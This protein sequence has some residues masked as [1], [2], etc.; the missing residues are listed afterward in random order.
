MRR[1][2]RGEEVDEEGEGEEDGEAEEEVEEKRRERVGRCTGRCSRT[3]A[4]FSL[5]LR[6]LDGARL[7]RSSVARSDEA[8]WQSPMRGA[9][10]WVSRT[11]NKLR[12]SSG[13]PHTHPRLTR[14]SHNAQPLC[15]EPYGLV[16]LRLSMPSSKTIV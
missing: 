13:E 8:Q 5:I 9:G 1:A 10:A 7:A 4:T 15:G 6:V 11:S 12:R 2:R 14:T 3:R 16:P